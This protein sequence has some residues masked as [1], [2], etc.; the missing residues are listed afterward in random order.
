MD[1]RFV[2]FLA[3]AAFSIA[4]QA[5]YSQDSGRVVELFTNAAGAIAVRLDNGYPNSVAARQ[6]SSSDGV[7][8]GSATPN[9]TLTAA[10]F[11]AKAKGSSVTITTEGCEGGW[12]KVVDIYVK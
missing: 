11:L 4:A 3:G 6:C 1:K 7:W 9:P 12:L 10:L 8:A 2:F 5:G